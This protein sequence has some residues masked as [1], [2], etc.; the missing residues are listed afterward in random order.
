[1][2]VLRFTA[3]LFFLLKLLS[4]VLKYL[5]VRTLSSGFKNYLNPGTSNR[6]MVL[7]MPGKQFIL[8]CSYWTK[9][10]ISK[11]CTM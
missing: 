9:Y 8:F 5:V 1:M 4:P 11:M 2:D 7:L 6:N 3:A 10:S